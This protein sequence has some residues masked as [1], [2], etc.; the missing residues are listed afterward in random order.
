MTFTTLILNALYAYCVSQP[1]TNIADKLAQDS[2]AEADGS[3]FGK[4]QSSN[5]ESQPQTARMF[6]T[7]TTPAVSLLHLASELI[8]HHHT[9][10]YLTKK[11]SYI[12]LT[13]ISALV[14]AGWIVTTSFWMHCELPPLNN[15]NPGIC[16]AQVRGH[17]MYGIHEVSIAK[18]VMA[19][20]IAITYMAHVVLLGMGIKVQ[21]RLWRIRGDGEAEHGEAQEIVVTVSEQMQKEMYLASGGR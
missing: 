7:L 4:R 17:F 10:R 8:I 1:H 20:L 12:I 13:T 6:Y 11:L 14:T 15:S 2:N 18:A 5:R 9:P 3:I 19:W 21:R 16:P